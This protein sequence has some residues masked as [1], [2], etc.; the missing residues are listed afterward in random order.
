MEGGNRQDAVEALRAGGIDL[1]GRP[2]SAP[3]RRE[4]ARL[5]RHLRDSGGRTIGLAP[6]DDQVAVPALALLLG[7]A[8]TRQSGLPVAV[9]DATA[10]WP[11][12]G[13][14]GKG[15]VSPSPPVTWIDERLAFVTPVPFAPRNAI[16]PLRRLCEDQGQFE[17]LV[18]DLT[19]LD[20]LG[21]L[22]AA[23]ALL[24]A[25]LLVARSGRT[26][27]RQVRAWLSGPASARTAGVLIS[28]C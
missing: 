9:V 1:G 23:I 20:H 26:T 3:E 14:S 2:G 21:E 28:G 15:A 13:E 19:G 24:D 5:A 22:Y 8:L 18:V 4:C 6:A 11:A 27:A 25:V 17:H 10:S 12:G 7:Q 16:A